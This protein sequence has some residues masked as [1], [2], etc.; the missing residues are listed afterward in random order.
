MIIQIAYI[1]ASFIAVAATIPQVK[2]LLA[3]KESD[4]LNLTSWSTWTAYQVVATI[5]GISISAWLYVV[6]STAWIIFYVTMLTL[7]V[8]YRRPIIQFK[9]KQLLR[10][11][12]P[13]MVTVDNAPYKT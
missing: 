4:E 8:R 3:T 6:V 5:Y 1:I 11:A 2:Q 13:V 7:I 12:T 9:Q 10:K